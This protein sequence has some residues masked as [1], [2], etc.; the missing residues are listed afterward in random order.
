MLNAEKRRTQKI[1]N[2]FFYKFVFFLKGKCK[3]LAYSS[4]NRFATPNLAR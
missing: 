3:E 1:E 4:C 2:F